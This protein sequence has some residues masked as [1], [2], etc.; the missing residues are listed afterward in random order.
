MSA[1]TNFGPRVN[2]MME[3][4]S[5]YCKVVSVLLQDPERDLLESLPELED[6]VDE[7]GPRGPRLPATTFSPTSERR[8]FCLFRRRIP[9][10]STEPVHNIESDIP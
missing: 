7:F 10:L 3:T 5:V 2:E 9:G 4:E 1:R 8:L 6:A